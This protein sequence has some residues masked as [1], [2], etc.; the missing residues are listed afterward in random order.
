MTRVPARTQLSAETNARE[1]ASKA[2]HL[3]KTKAPQPPSLHSTSTHTPS[4]AMSGLWP[5]RASKKEKP[6]SPPSPPDG[7]EH[8]SPPDDAF[9][10]HFK[11]DVCY[12]KHRHTTYWPKCRHNEDCIVQMFDGP[13]HGGRQ[14]FRCPRGTVSFSYVPFLPIC[15]RNN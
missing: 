5:R 4:T 14:F 13:K 2:P 1:R 11:H 10:L 3:Y 8:Y 6:P 7:P 12:G 15:V 9:P